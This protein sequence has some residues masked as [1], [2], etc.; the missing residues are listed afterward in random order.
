MRGLGLGIFLT[1]VIMGILFSGRRKMTDQEIIA[2]A[3][4]LGMVENTYL[5]DDGEAPTEENM[6][7]QNHSGDISDAPDTSDMADASKDPDGT[8]TEDASDTAGDPGAEDASDTEGDS[9][10]ETGAEASEG[11]G[12]AGTQEAPASSRPDAPVAEPEP[13]TPSSMQAND[14]GADAAGTA[15]NKPAENKQ[16][17]SRPGGSTNE[18][19]KQEDKPS[20]SASVETVTIVSGDGSY[21]VARK[22][23]EAGVVTSAETFDDFLCQNGYDK[24]LRTG[25]FRIPVDASDEQIARIVTGQE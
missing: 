23:K 19:T 8:G 11:A 4:E 13:D 20:A 25:T 21:T 18:M 22:L 12:S 5:A 14:A 9:D 16:T 10:S 15:G 24:K 1:A 3:R 17:G 2:R 7:D 6:E